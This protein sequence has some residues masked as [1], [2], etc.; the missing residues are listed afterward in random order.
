MERT[1]RLTPGAGLLHPVPLAAVGVLL[2]NDH[3]LKHAMPGALTG[4]L[5]DFAG[6]VFFPL[7]LQALWELGQRLRRGE[8]RA[9]QAV[10]VASTVATAAVFTAIQLWPPAGELYRN[11]LGALQWAPRALFALLSGAGVPSV[12][13]VLL[14][15]DATDVWALAVLPLPLWLGHERAASAGPGVA[16]PSELDRLARGRQ[17]DAGGVELRRS[18]GAIGDQGIDL[19]VEG[20]RR[21]QL[22]G[23]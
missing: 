23:P 20:P 1:A 6:M 4:K 11:G 7:F 5:S 19:E 22:F 9:S 12:A 3:V 8:A 16:L 18:S 17:R 13:P 15:P 14:T 2:L 10:L 21:R